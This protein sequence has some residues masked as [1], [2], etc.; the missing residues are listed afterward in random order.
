MPH[1]FEEFTIPACQGKA[2]TVRKGQTLRVIEVEGPQAADLIAMNLYN[3][4]ESFCAWL[5]WALENTYINPKK[6]YGKL[7]GAN[8]MFTVLTDKSGII[9][10]SPGRCSRPIYEKQYGIKYY[11]VNCQDI[12][13]ECIEPYGLTAWDVPDVINLFMTGSFREDGG[14]ELKASPVKKGDYI[15]LLA[16]MDLLCAISNCPDEMGVYND[17]SVK[18]LGIQIFD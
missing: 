16:E 15:D 3:L 17:F 4:K 11:H 10:L 12:L 7:P 13:A 8:V 1:N 5:T 9:W 18:P 2:F 14:R 6:L